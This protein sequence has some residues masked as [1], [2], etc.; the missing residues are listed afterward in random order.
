[1]TVWVVTKGWYYEGS[2]VIG[3]FDSL[4]K[5]EVF[6]SQDHG[7]CDFVEIETWKVS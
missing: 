4:T 1:M 5:A 2:V 6:K 3:V 7:Y